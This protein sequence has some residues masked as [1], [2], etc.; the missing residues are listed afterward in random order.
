MQS[1]ADKTNAVRNDFNSN[2]PSGTDA[3]SAV[4]HAGLRDAVASVHSS[5]SDN[6][7]KIG[8]KLEEIAKGAAAV[9]STFTDTDGELAGA[10]EDAKGKKGDDGK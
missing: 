3:S 4:G 9:V 1:V 2:A 5:W 10:L 6:R 8:R 7:E